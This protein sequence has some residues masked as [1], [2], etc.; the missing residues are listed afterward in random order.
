MTL[1]TALVLFVAAVLG[2]TLNAVAGGGSFISFPALLISGV[3]PIQANA[4]STIALWPGSAASIGAY[5]DSLTATRRT[6]LL[7]GIVS[8]IGGVLGAL[9]LINTKPAT[10]SLLIPWLLLLATLLFTFGGK[11]TGTL[12]ARLSKASGPAWLPLTGALV[13]QFIISAYG[14]FFGGG[15][16]IL[17]LASFAVLG[18]ENIHEMNA[19]KAVLATCIN[20]VAVITFILAGKIFWP[21]ALV[22]IVGAIAGGYGGAYYAR[23][24]DPRIVRRFVILVGF[25]MSLYFF[26]TTFA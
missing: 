14:G 6:L 22:M 21:E 19:L 2:G 23:R 7:Y 9:V 24:I 1:L 13:L 3:P 12:R 25:G 4:T 26:I 17:M 16:G 5:K 11:L 18:M 20:G 8:I 10:F 15:I